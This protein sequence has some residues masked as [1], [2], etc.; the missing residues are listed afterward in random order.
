MR[1]KS[2]HEI[3]PNYLIISIIRYL[4]KDAGTTWLSITTSS[5]GLPCL[6]RFRFA[7]TLTRLACAGLLARRQLAGH[8]PGGGAEL[9]GQINNG[10]HVYSRLHLHVR[11]LRC[12][13]FGRPHSVS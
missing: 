7:L 3:V 5:R 4:V 11:R 2:Q 13:R 8:Q 9:D 10:I 6:L 12:F 1:A